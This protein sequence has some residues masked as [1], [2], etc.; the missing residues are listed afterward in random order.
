MGDRYY[1]DGEIMNINIGID[2]WG[3]KVDTLLSNIKIKQDHKT[4]QTWNLLAK[5]MLNEP[6]TSTGGLKTAPVFVKEYQPLV[7][8]V[9]QIASIILSPES[10]KEQHVALSNK[11]KA[12]EQLQ[13]TER[14]NTISN[15]EVHSYCTTLTRECIAL[16]KKE[17]K[18]E[19]E[20]K[21]FLL[22]IN[23]LKSQNPQKQLSEDVNKLRKQMKDVSGKI[24]KVKFDRL[25]GRIRNLDG[26]LNSSQRQGL[27]TAISNN[28]GISYGYFG[29]SIQKKELEDLIKSLTLK[30][31]QQPLSDDQ[32]QNLTQNLEKLDNFF[33]NFEQFSKI[34]NKVKLEDGEI[35]RSRLMSIWTLSFPVT[36][37]QKRL[38]QIRESRIETLNAINA[39]ELPKGLTENLDVVKAN[40]NFI[41]AMTMLSKE[42][43]ASSPNKKTIANA[44]ELLNKSA[45]YSKPAEIASKLNFNDWKKLSLDQKQIKQAHEDILNA[46]KEGGYEQFV[47]KKDVDD[48]FKMLKDPKARTKGEIIKCLKTIAAVLTLPLAWTAVALAFAVVCSGIITPYLW[49]FLIDRLHARYSQ[50]NL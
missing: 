33:T 25:T 10:T 42:L 45:P 4:L 19:L 15:P 31:E 27:L 28:Q 41:L 5:Q 24:S 38:K 6:A 2:S 36:S 30:S 26:K 22:E 14:S 21:I 50:R 1:K 46:I 12:L 37:R 13:K 39:T 18:A 17:H 49:A 3:E 40:L 43:N 20:K 47:S 34:P 8:E 29:S 7:N 48:V 16:L 32:Y 11:I 35:F 9:N 23:E 44:Y